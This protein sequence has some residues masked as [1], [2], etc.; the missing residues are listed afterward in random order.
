LRPPPYLRWTYSR[1]ADG[2]ISSAARSSRRNR[3][4]SLIARWTLRSIAPSSKK[5]MTS[6]FGHCRE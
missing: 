6:Q 2:L 4:A 3:L 5:M 1:G